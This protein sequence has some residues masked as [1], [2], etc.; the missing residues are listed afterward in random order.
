MHLG[1]CST[2]ENRKK[3]VR[4]FHAFR[5]SRNIPRAWIALSCTEN[6]LVF[7]YN[8]AMSQKNPPNQLNQLNYSFFDSAL[9]FK[10]MCVFFR[11]RWEVLSILCPRYANYYVSRDACSDEFQEIFSQDFSGKKWQPLP[12]KILCPYAPVR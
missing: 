8:S 11:Y 9:N 1:C 3:H 10:L 2:F 4:V 5:N 7:L 6:H 12:L